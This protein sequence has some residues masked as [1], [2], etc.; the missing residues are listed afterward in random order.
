MKAYITTVHFFAKGKRETR[1]EIELPDDCPPE[2]WMMHAY[3]SYDPHAANGPGSA[4]NKF[5]SPADKEALNA[6]ETK[7]N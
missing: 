7:P 5:L 3:I 4:D 6:K 1:L 2:L